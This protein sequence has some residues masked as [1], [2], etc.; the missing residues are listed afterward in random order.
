MRIRGVLAR[1]LLGLVLVLPAVACT[2]TSADLTLTVDGET[3]LVHY[4][5]DV[6][7]RPLMVVLHGLGSSAEEMRAVS[8]MSGF[9]DRNGFAVVYPDAHRVPAPVP[10]TPG[11]PPTAPPALTQQ[12]TSLARALDEAQGNEPA[13]ARAWNAGTSCC[14]GASGDDVAYLRR[15]VQAVAATV[16]VD[17][18]RVYVVGLSNGGM[19]AT[20]AVCE[21]PDLFAA[22][23]TVAGPYLG[24][25]CSRP[26][27][28]HL[29][30]GNDPFVP[31]LGGVPPGAI[32][33]ID[34]DWCRCSFPSSATETKRFGGYVS[35]TFVPGAT[36]SWPTSTGSWHL[37][38]N[39]VLWQA[40]R[41]FRR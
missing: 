9:A 26:V 15:V 5:P 35:T 37:D 22:A 4:V 3:S 32:G 29:H 17:M 38:G 21:A 8:G 34:Y 27:W 31:Y 14:G 16:P 25:R 41:G 7:A 33:L 28:K 11:L 1:G 6:G 30:G 39:A 36:H 20:R 18:H 24:T 19:M 12:R 10:P 23:G 13:T 40:L 2:P